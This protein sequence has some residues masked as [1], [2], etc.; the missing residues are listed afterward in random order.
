MATVNTY[1]WFDNTAEEAAKFYAA[2]IPGSR[3]VDV[4]HYPYGAAFTT[5]LELAGHAVTF[6]NG[7]PGHPSTDSVS[8]CLLVE[9]QEEIDL[10]WDALT[11]GGTA[12][13]GGWLTD[14]FGVSW[15]V[16]PTILPLLMSAEDPAKT[17]AVGLAVQAM[18]K[19]DIK[20]LRLA[21]DRG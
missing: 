8:L 3:V 4:A 14:R 9:T 17:L 15:Q 10:V 6:V 18:T 2:V 11:E 16:A 13:P 21:Y 20:M 12:G 19:L 5:S 7:G 1:V